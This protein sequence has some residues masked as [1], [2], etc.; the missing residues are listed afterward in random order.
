MLWEKDNN[1]A[2]REKQIYGFVLLQK[3]SSVCLEITLVNQ[4]HKLLSVSSVTSLAIQVSCLLT[5]K[6]LEGTWNQPR[7]LLLTFA[8]WSDVTDASWKF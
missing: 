1:F 6:V 8:L 7:D 4:S 5:I 3:L 2:D